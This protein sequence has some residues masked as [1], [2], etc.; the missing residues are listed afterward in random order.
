LQTV[1]RIMKQGE[2]KVDTVGGGD[3]DFMGIPV[4]NGGGYQGVATATIT[5]F[6]NLNHLF[7]KTAA[8]RN[9]VPLKARESFN[10]D[11][12][13]R[14]LAWAGNMTGRNLFLHG[15]AQQ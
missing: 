15:Y 2:V 13:V 8:K 7:F 6:L 12:T 10:Q 3:L 14:Y 4:I 11:A 1:Q 9:F 5:R